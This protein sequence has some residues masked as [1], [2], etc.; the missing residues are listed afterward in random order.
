M[1]FD[2]YLIKHKFTESILNRFNQ[3]YMKKAN[4]IF[5]IA[6][7]LILFSSTDSFS[8]DWPQWRGITRDSKVTG[9]KVPLK[10]R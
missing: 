5:S 9:F 1:L 7:A 8:Q 10:W 3:L 4:L 6:A 2:F